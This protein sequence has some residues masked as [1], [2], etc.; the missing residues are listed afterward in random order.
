MIDPGQK[1]PKIIG[2]TIL[3]LEEIVDDRQRCYNGLQNC[4]ALLVEQLEVT[5]REITAKI[6]ELD[7]DICEVFFGG[8][9]GPQMV[10]KGLQHFW[11]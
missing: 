9:Q 11:K 4:R 10:I 1:K 6:S 8:C 7:A 2:A 3:A 5:Q